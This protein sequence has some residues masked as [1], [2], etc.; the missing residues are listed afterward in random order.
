MV[1]EAAMGVRNSPRKPPLLPIE[2]AVP[3]RCAPANVANSAYA[4]PCRAA[5]ERAGGNGG[6]RRRADRR[7]SPDI[8]RRLAAYWAYRYTVI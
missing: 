8:A 3:E 7:L 4:T 1:E 2:S 5:R 6:Y